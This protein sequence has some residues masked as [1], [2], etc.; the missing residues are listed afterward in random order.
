MES[1][2]SEEKESAVRIICEKNVG[3]KPGP[4]SETTRELMSMRVDNQPKS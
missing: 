3:F 1:P 2:T 4:R